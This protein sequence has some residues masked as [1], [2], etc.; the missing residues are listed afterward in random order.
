MKKYIQDIITELNYIYPEKKVTIINGFIGV[1]NSEG[2]L[3]HTSYLGNAYYEIDGSVY[4]DYNCKK[5]S[6]KLLIIK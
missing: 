1:L 5:G 2:R 3:F 6:K 4:T